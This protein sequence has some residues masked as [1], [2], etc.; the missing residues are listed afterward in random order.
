[1]I[2]GFAIH[3]APTDHGGIIPSTQVRSSQ[4]GNLFVRAGD[5]HMCPK[6]KCWSTIIPSHNHVI[7]DGK[8]IAYVGDQLTCGAKIL[9]QQSHVVGDSSSGMQSIP[10]ASPVDTQQN[11][12]FKNDILKKYDIILQDLIAEPF[13]P[14]G[15]PTHE[16]RST[17]NTLKFHGTVLTGMFETISFEV[18]KEGK[19]IEV[20]RIEGWYTANKKFSFKWDGFIN[21]IYES[22]FFT[23]PKGVEFRIKGFNGGNEMCI[24]EKSFN[25]KYFNKDWI[26]VRINRKTLSIHIKLRLNLSN[27]GEIGFEDW[28]SI[29]KEHIKKNTPPY[30]SR[31]VSFDN[32]KKMAFDGMEYYW[33]RNSSHPTGKNVNINN[34]PYQVYLTAIAATQQAMPSMPLIYATNW[35]PKRSCNWEL[36]RKTYYNTGYI[37]FHSYSRGV[38]W[39]FWDKSKSDQVFKYTFSHEIGHELLLAF[40]GQVYSKGHKGTSGIVLQSPNSGTTYPRTGEIDIMKYAEE[41][42]NKISG[43]YSRSIADE[44]DVIG[45]LFI[46]GI[47]KK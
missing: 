25:F 15:V 35:G 39:E 24:S 10:S 40:G 21:D 26:D 38:M 42:E 13:I 18:K 33:S 7:F 8:P 31:T 45:L 29:P 3:N 34:V 46:S 44:K 11:E 1:M 23:T 47:S 2:K 19:F 30:T 36:S 14:L 37:F 27:G 17:N 28:K 12:N 20:G 9:P 43:F 4:Q 5:G 16:G 6:C 22:K 41:N 32:L